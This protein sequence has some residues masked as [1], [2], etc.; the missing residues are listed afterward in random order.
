VNAWGDSFKAQEFY[1]KTFPLDPLSTVSRASVLDNGFIKVQK[2]INAEGQQLSP[3]EVEDSAIELALL[4]T[5]PIIATIQPVEEVITPAA[6][7]RE[8]STVERT[9]KDGNAYNIDDIKLG[10]L[11]KMGYTPSEVGEIL[12]EIRKEI[13]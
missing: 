13:C 3:D 9:L 5:T 7:T 8:R 12:K 2:T 6:E 11:I 4:G 1:G 10:M